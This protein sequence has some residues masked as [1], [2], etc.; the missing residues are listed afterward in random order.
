MV[1]TALG[2]VVT[3]PS[4]VAQ[5]GTAADRSTKEYREKKKKSYTATEL[6]QITPQWP[7]PYLSFLPAGAKPDYDY[8]RALMRVEGQKR[9]QRM[10]LTPSF[11]RLI[12]V[13]ESEPN[14]TQATAQFITGFGTGAGDDPATDINGNL[15]APPV[16]TAIGPFAEDDGAIPLA[17]ATGLTTGNAVI[18]SATI[19]DGLFG[20]SSGDYDFY[21][22]SGV[23]AS[24]IILVDVDTPVGNLD[25]VV[26]LYN[27]AGSLLAF[28][29]D[30]GVSFDS[31]LEFTA[32]ANDN[33]FVVVLGF[34]F[35]PFFQSNPFDSGSGGGAGSTGT[36]DVTI[37]FRAEEY[38][39]AR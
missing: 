25:P 27:S 28:N 26:G 34:H 32:P 1:L 20:A 2:V 29:D 16:P 10:A 39:A 24:Q 11:T 7:N 15:A 4:T 17:N 9:A 21:V 19:G 36:Y 13:T 6:A 38:E 30:D 12:S 8:W 33:Y 18:A 37:N 22:I 23:T 31:F 35:G 14:D 5:D 3:A